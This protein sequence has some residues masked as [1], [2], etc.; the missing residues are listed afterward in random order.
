MTNND[1]FQIL[2]PGLLLNGFTKQ[3]LLSMLV[4]AS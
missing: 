2:F 3:V 1:D 4:K